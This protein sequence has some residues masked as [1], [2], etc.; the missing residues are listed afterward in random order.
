MPR[1][2]ASGLV[3]LDHIKTRLGLDVSRAAWVIINETNVFT[4][5]GFDLVPQLNGAFVRG[6]ITRGCLNV[7]AKPC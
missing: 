3:V 7:V 1:T 6:M 5:P 4:W 2:E